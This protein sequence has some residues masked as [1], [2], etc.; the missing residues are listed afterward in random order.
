MKTTSPCVLLQMFPEEIRQFADG[1]VHIF[2]HPIRLYV[3][4]ARDKVQF[5][6]I[7]SRRFAETLFGHVEGIGKTAGHHQ[8]RLVDEMHP[9]AGVKRHQV[10]KAT[11][12]V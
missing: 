10:Y 5:L 12:F 9:I 4:C 3:P 11:L 2:R 8:E 7:G 1:L 6:V